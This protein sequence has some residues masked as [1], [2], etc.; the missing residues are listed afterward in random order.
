MEKVCVCA[1]TPPGTDLLAWTHKAGG[2]GGEGSPNPGI[3]YLTPG[4]EA[5]SWDVALIASALLA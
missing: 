2:E 5:A 4:K 1:T 3:T